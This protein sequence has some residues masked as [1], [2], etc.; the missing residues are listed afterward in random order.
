MNQPVAPNPAEMHEQY[1]VPAMFRPWL[2]GAAARG[3]AA[4]R[5]MRYWHRLARVVCR[6]P[7]RVR[8][9]PFKSTI[10]TYRETD[11]IT[12]PML[13]TSRLPSHDSR[14]QILLS[15]GPDPIRSGVVIATLSDRI[16]EQQPS[17]N[18]GQI[19]GSQGCR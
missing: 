13:R 3:A 1:F 18:S 8:Q 14:H 6:L 5:G 4:R 16:A 9:L 19:R 7:W 15:G 17:T 12:F 2:R 10:R 11:V